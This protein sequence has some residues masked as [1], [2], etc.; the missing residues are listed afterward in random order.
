[1]ETVANCK[2]QYMMKYALYLYNCK[3]NIRCINN[4]LFFYER[5]TET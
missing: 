1:M 4:Q 2:Y 3:C 5:F